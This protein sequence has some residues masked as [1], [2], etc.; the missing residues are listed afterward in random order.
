MCGVPAPVISMFTNF[1][2]SLPLNFLFPTFLKW[3]WWGG[4]LCLMALA[5]N[6]I[7]R[8]WGR[9]LLV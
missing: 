8:D 1:L 9:G 6:P 3:G 4:E 7:I 5:C 2:I